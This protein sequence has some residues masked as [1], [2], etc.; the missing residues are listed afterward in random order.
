[1][2]NNTKEL[3]DFI[4]DINKLIIADPWLEMY[5]PNGDYD[6]GEVYAY[7]HYVYFLLNGLERCYEH[8]PVN[9]KNEF[10]PKHM[11]ADIIGNHVEYINKLVDEFKKFYD[12]D[13]INIIL[14]I[15]SQG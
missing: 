8:C 10:L 1:M 13:F 15:N 9:R 7:Q 11:I 14:S 6:K 3:H 2:T 12:P 4:Q 5:D